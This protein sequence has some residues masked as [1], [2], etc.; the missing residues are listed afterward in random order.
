M[1]E[2][3]IPDDGG[4]P[5]DGSAWDLAARVRQLEDL[6]RIRCVLQ[7][8]ARAL[9]RGDWDLMRTCFTAD[10]TDDHGPFQ[11]G[12]DALVR[13][14][15]ELMAEYWGTMHVLGQS[16]IEL[17]GDTAAVETYA[18]SFHRRHGR[19]GGGDEDTVTGIRYIDRF[20]RTA[21]GW[22]V[23]RRITVQEWNTTLPAREWMNSA[24]WVNGR[25]DRTDVSYSAGLP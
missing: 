24:L 16:H 23:A 11:G 1:H 4:A 15:R 8:Y 2:G 21:G 14:T 5:P 25:T 19:D 13:G 3:P 7:T 12:V 22:L 9:D 17:D 6:H 10:A 18:L 20:A